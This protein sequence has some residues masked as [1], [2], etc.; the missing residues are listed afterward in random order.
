MLL[1]QKEHRF[2]I[3]IDEIKVRGYELPCHSKKKKLTTEP[4]SN[5]I[6]RFCHISTETNMG[7][8]ASINTTWY[9]IVYK[10]TF[11]GQEPKDSVSQKYISIHGE[12][13]N[14]A[15]CNNSIF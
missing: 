8:N 11:T 14:V 4:F 5:E 9:S 13:S 12:R 2:C 7:E 3:D 10:S 1:L 6:A 15:D